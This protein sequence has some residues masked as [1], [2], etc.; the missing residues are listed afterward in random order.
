MKWFAIA[1]ILL[2]VIGS[3]V[4]GASAL[5]PYI[6]DAI[7]AVQLIHGDTNN[8]AKKQLVF[9]G[10]AVATATGKVNIDPATAQ[11]ITSCVFDT[12]DN[13]KKIVQANTPTSTPPAQ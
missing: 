3:L 5:I 7:G 8:A 1:K 12:I 11:A 10:V 2:P 4:P 13:V 6:G 9:D